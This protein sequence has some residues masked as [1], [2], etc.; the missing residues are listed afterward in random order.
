MK[1]SQIICKNCGGAFTRTSLSH[2]KNQNIICPY[3]N[4]TYF[5]GAKHSKIGAQLEAEFERDI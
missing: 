4:T 2:I 1:P 3:C 5:V